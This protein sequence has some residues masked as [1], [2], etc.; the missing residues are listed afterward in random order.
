MTKFQ[1]ENVSL[2]SLRLLFVNNKF[3][4]L[5]YSISGNNH[6]VRFLCKQQQEVEESDWRIRQ[7]IE[8]FHQIN[9]SLR[10]FSTHALFCYNSLQRKNF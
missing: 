2:E 7:L 3:G 8:V 6:G 4:Q 10:F 9:E 1:S 5:R